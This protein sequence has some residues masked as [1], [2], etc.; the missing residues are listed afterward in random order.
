MWCLGYVAAG[1]V[2][3]AVL[4]DFGRVNLEHFHAAR[5]VGQRDLDLPVQA[6]RT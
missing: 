1:G 4:V 3:T 5:L 6:A 2:R